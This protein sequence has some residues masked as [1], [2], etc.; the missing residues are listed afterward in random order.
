MGHLTKIANDVVVV[1]EKGENADLVKEQIS[2]M[3]LLK[4]SV[5]PSKVLFWSLYLIIPHK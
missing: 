2:G 3:N 1:T 4:S 5:T